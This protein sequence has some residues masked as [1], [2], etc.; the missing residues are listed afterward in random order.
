MY[1]DPTGLDAIV[2]N[3]LENI[4]GA[5]HMSAFVQD[6]D[7]IWY[8]FY[9][10]INS[11]SLTKVD[12]S[13]ILNDPEKI[14]TWLE[15]QGLSNGEYKY[16]GFCYILGDFSESKDYYQK[17]ADQYNSDIEN[18]KLGWF[19]FKN[20]NYN[21]VTRNCA[22]E[23]MKG[24]YKGKIGVNGEQTVKQ[25]HNGSGYIIGISPNANLYNLQNVYGSKTLNW[26]E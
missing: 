1:I 2:A 25:I 22:Q 7:G 26:W 10:G 9:W 15:E 24:L 6:D 13:S 19:G 16:D 4:G 21:L 23:T 14:N 3:Q 12:D 8:F 18:K 5:G 20:K 17:L 11:V